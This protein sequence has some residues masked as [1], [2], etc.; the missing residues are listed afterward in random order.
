MNSFMSI[1]DANAISAV[2]A[3]LTGLAEDLQ[4]QIADVKAEIEGIE[5]ERPWGNDQ[6]GDGFVETYMQP[7]D[8]QPPL[9]DAVL[10]GMDASG[11]ILRQLGD[12]TV[13]AM[14]RYQGAEAQNAEEIRAANPDA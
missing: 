12:M 6:F 1:E 8:E 7:V 10:E 11:D 14:T 3:R 4:A 13:L 2:G 9:R 5:A